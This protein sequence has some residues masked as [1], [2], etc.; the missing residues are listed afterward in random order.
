MN[1]S[2][3]KSYSN[4]VNVPATAVFLPGTRVIPGNPSASVLVKQ[5]A[6]GHHNVPTAEQNAIKS[7]ITAGALNN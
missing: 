1:L 7:W 6:T 2:A 4:L 5:L 3:G